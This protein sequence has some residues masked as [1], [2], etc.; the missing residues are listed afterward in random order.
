MVDKRQPGQD[1][2]AEQLKRPTKRNSHV[3]CLGRLPLVNFMKKKR[4]PC[5]DIRGYG[6]GSEGGGVDKLDYI[7]DRLQACSL[8]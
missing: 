1:L 7:I 4:V 8:L 6:L 3:I 5:C 2:M